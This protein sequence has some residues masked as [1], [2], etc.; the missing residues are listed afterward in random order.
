MTIDKDTLT[1]TKAL[2]SDQGDYTC[3]AYSDVGAT[4]SNISRVD[5]KGMYFCFVFLIY[6]QS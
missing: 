4:R 1:I 3:T 2:L 5:I 6:L